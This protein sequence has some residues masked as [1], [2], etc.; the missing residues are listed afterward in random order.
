MTGGH[1]F[2][3]V[4]A[5]YAAGALDQKAFLHVARKRGELMAEAA[6]MFPGA[7]TAIAHPAAAIAELLA[8]WNTGVVIANHNTPD[9]VVISGIE[10]A[11]AACEERLRQAGIRHQRLPV[12]TAFHSTVVRPATAPFHAYLNH[13]PVHAPAVPVYANSTAAVYSSVPE[14]VRETLADQ[15]ALPVLFA[16]QVEAMYAAGARIFVE[17]GPGTV[18]TNLVKSCLG[19]RPHLAVALDRK[20]EHGLTS[21]WHALAQLAAAGVPLDLGPVWEGVA[22]GADPRMRRTP[23]LAVPLSGVNYAKPYP[24]T[25]GAAGLAA[26]NLNGRDARD[27]TAATLPTPTLAAPA[28][29]GSAAKQQKTSPSVNEP[30]NNPSSRLSEHSVAGNGHAVSQL[31]PPAPAVRPSPAHVPAPAAEP[32]P[33]APTA[34]LAP[35]QPCR[36]GYT[37]TGS[38]ARRRGICCAGSEGKQASAGG[39]CAR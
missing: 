22:V 19:D 4:T 7:M 37:F 3:E 25:N 13:V 6:A 11:V 18:L 2:G 23:K 9:Q 32:L 38:T 36:A 5:L 12:A 26:P 16:E 34:H 14:A 28:A 33:P 20:G 10:A 24:P 21:L 15:I 1:S 29:N 27:I 17:V 39:G 31:Q 8:Q 30:T 35:V